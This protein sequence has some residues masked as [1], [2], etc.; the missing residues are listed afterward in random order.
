[1]DEVE[2]LKRI[3]ETERHEENAVRM[4]KY[5]RDQ[6]TFIGI[7]SPVRK[8]LMKQFFNETKI[9]KQPFNREFVSLLWDLENRE[10]QYAA[11]DYIERFLNKLEK[12]D[13]LLMEKLIVSKS[14]WDTVD[15]LAQKPVGIICFSNQE[16][17]NETV[18]KWSRSE[19]IWLRRT[20][21]I[22]QLKYKDQT[23]ESLLFKFIKLNAESN[24]F[25]IQKAIGWA[26][27]EYSKTNREAV[28]EFIES[29]VLSPLSVRE[30]SKYLG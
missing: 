4:E 24:E 8:Q 23:D 14:W 17:I 11:L 9:L 25:F 3:F 20:S 16:C 29:T 21:I 19:N 15:M 6:F 22:F 2:I 7:K 30:G 27:R 5:M 1:M 28:K 18:E 10:Y 13:L 12:K 26:L